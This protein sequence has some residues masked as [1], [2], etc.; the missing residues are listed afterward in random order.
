MWGFPSYVARKP[1]NKELNV[2]EC[3]GVIEMGDSFKFSNICLGNMIYYF[4]DWLKRNRVPYY[5][6]ISLE[7]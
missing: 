1:V 5:H 4:M 3:N 2:Y 7:T 6:V